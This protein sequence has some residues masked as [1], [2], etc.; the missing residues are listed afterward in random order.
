MRCLQWRQM[1][2][3]AHPVARMER[4]MSCDKR[5]CA[6]GFTALIALTPQLAQA[7]ST[8]TRAAAYSTGYGLY[9]GQMQRAV[10][11]STR[12]ANGNRI[13]VDGT[14]FMGADQSVYSSTSTWGA[15]DSYSGAG[16][17]GG[18]TAIG[19]YLN[20]VVQGNYNTVIVN[21]NQVNN[22]NVTANADRKSQS[23]NTPETTTLNGQLDGF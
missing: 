11:P 23:S 20:V 8:D 6:L 7:Q 9:R 3:K 19:N 17:Y 12:D 18:A 2:P 5:L 4:A 21:S 10:N 13:L 15:G 16:A 22:G 14:L 1:P